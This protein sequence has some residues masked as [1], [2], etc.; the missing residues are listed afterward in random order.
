VTILGLRGTE[1]LV[2]NEEPHSWRQGII[3]IFPNG[4]TPLMALAGQGDSESVSDYQFSWWDKM[5]PNRRIFIN[6]GSGYSAAATS[7][8][9]DDAAGGSASF[10]V[11]AGTVLMNERTFE[12]MIVANDPTTSTI[13]IDRAKG[14][15]AAAIMLD[16]DPLLIVGSSYEDGSSAKI[17]AVQYDPT[18]RFNY[19]QIFDDSLKL[20]R[21]VMKTNLRTGDKYQET[22]RETLQIHNIGLEW[23][24]LFGER[25]SEAGV[26]NTTQV[27]RTFTG[28]FYYWI[29][30]NVHDAGGPVTYFELMDF[31]EED[32]RYGANEK[33]LLAGSTAINALNKLAKLEMTMNTVPGPDSFGLNVKEIIS[34]FGTLDVVNHPLLSDNPTFRTWAFGIDMSFF[35]I[36]TLD[37]TMIIEHVEENHTKQR[38]DE[39]YSDL[40]WE[41]QNE[42]SHFLWKRISAA[43]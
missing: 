10:N 5:L 15:T 36:R 42:R 20:S 4:E 6:N 3:H 18:Q 33:L 41:I 11:K 13:Q 12:H 35:I 8:V 14:S 40:G 43:A 27:L 25:F 37:D 29:A 28:G 1:N 34:P 30:T 38:E 24:A 39:F 23:S 7:A 32:F 16:N 21:R 9:V 19:T 22:R 2:A 31:L 26:N 17:A